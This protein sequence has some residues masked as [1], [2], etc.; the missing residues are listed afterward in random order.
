MSTAFTHAFVG[1]LVGR[2]ASLDLPRRRLALLCALVA[3]L[4]DLDVAA[5]ALGVPYGASLGH[6]GFSHSLLFAVL[7]ATAGSLAFFRDVPRLSRGWWSVVALLALA[8]ASHGLLDAATDAGLGVGFLLPFDD[9][10]FFLPWRPLATS[11]IGVAA[12]FDARA[13]AI[14]A[15]EVAWVW[16]P[17]LLAFAARAGWRRRRRRLAA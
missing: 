3:V 4:P 9:T 12:F 1:L 7:V 13:L 6:R 2:G 10:R 11:P 16:L 5:F 8:G 14:L 17:A 15:N